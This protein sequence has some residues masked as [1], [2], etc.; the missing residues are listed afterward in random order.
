M[1]LIGGILS[2]AGQRQTNKTNIQLSRE[3]REHDVNM[4]H[5]QNQY[6]SPEMQMQRLK[7]AGLNPNL[8]YGDGSASTGQAGSP[9]K[10]PVP[11]VTNEMAHLAQASLAPMISQ[12]Q[13]WKI[14]E[15]RLN[16]IEADTRGKENMATLNNLRA[17][18]TGLSNEKL[19]IER[20]MWNLNAIHKSAKLGSEAD[21]M[22]SRALQEDLKEKNLHSYLPSILTQIG[23]RNTLLN[24]QIKSNRLEN[25]LNE[26]LKPYGARSTDTLIQ[27]LLMRYMISLRDNVTGFESRKPKYKKFND[28]LR[29]PFGL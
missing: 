22:N 21:I 14:N 17:I 16:N 18:T 12:Y 2:Y 8:I 3:S 9:Q 7:E 24:E 10:A 13:N 1:S 23:L 11:Q 19:R 29:K 4:W 20:P 28:K 15:A 26:T 5:K 6:N 25:E 27:R